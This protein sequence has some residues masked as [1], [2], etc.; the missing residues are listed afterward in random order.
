MIIK[1]L[2]R[3]RDGNG[4]DILRTGLILRLVMGILGWAALGVLTGLSTGFFNDLWLIVMFFGI[5]IPLQAF[6]IFELPFMTRSQIRPVFWARNLS[7]FSG[8]AMKSAALLAKSPRGLF[9]GLYLIEEF[10]W[11]AIITLRAWQAGFLGGHWDRKVF[12]LLWRTGLLACIA[13]F[14]VL[15]D[16]R[17]PFLFL[18][19][20]GQ[21]EWLGSYA[22][23]VSLIDMAL[24]LPISLAAAIFPKVA[25][26]QESEAATYHFER[27]RM[28]SC[29]VWFALAFAI[30]MHFLAPYI[31]DV[32]YQGKYPHAENI[33][34]GMGW[35][36]VWSFF[37]VGR[38]KWF[39]LEN[40]LKEWLLLTVLSLGLQAVGL[41]W[42]LPSM[43]LNAILVAMFASQIGASLLLIWHP[44]VRESLIIFIKS[45]LGIGL[46]WRRT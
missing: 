44:R 23:T 34:R 18:Q 30:P 6:T 25:K 39:A 37:N 9:V 29:L 2:V 11:K 4:N 41:W 3:Q 43:G 28:S 26:A 19:S 16:Q 45:L 42:L 35:L 8:V 13:S 38:F 20:M 33:L 5:S 40:A 32:L 21:Q 31:L 22:V 36:S 17:L 15:F 24:L 10:L 46:V 27:Q 12:D 1:E 14:T 7:Y